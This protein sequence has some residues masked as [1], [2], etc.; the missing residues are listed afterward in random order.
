M[1]VQKV[2]NDKILELD[3]LTELEYIPSPVCSSENLRWSGFKIERFLVPD[4]TTT[5]DK[6]Y[7]SHVVAV[8]LGGKWKSNLPVV[9]GRRNVNY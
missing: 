3:S 5:P 4:L 7:T 9:G 2:T 8:T 1:S 6:F